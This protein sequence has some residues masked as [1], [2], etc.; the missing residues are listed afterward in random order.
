[1][2]TIWS[3]ILNDFVSC[4]NQTQ[5]LSYK[6]TCEGADDMVNFVEVLNHE[7]LS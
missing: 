5:G 7:G 4:S 1:M 3:T 6:H 2:T